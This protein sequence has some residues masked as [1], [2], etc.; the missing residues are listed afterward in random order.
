MII[1]IIGALM[2]G[3]LLI[4]APGFAKDGNPLGGVGMPNPEPPGVGI[5]A[6][7]AN[8][9]TPRTDRIGGGGGK[10]AAPA[11]TPG[12]SPWCDGDKDKSMGPPMGGR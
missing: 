10:G 7:G 12:C 5:K 11:T 9:T 6:K 2:F 4:A 8:T 1:R 3:G